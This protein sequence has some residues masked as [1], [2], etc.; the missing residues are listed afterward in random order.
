MISIVGFIGI[1]GIIVIMGIIG[2]V[3]IIGIIG[4]IGLWPAASP[5]LALVLVRWRKSTILRVIAWKRSDT[6]Q[7]L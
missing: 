1:M 4:I 6:G 5:S 2:F 3:G 7:N